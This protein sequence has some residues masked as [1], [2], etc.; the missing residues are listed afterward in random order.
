RWWLVVYA[1]AINLGLGALRLIWVWVALRLTILRTRQRGEQ[2]KAPSWRLIVATSLAGVRGAVTLAGVMTL[3]LLMT[4][5]TPFPS[6]ELVI[7]L[8]AA[9]ILSS[10][11]VA[12]FGLPPLLK[13]LVLP[14]ETATLREESRA[15]RDAAAVAISAIETARRD[16]LPRFTDEKILADAAARVVALYQRRIDGDVDI[17][18]DA[19]QIRKADQAE[20]ALRVAGLKA[21][22]EKIF[23]LTRDHLI[24]NEVSRKLVREIDL[25]ESRHQ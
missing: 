24:S 1:L 25:L 21:E 20:Q 14:P 9:V 7:F 6:R 3:P 8:A 16:L 5:G 11:V 4:D 13:G 15:R 10:L 22:R 17:D 2:I 18:S 12:S 23:S 19:A